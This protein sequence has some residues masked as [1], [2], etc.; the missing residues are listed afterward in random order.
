MTVAQGE[1]KRFA[2]QAEMALSL[3][4]LRSAETPSNLTCLRGLSLNGSNPSP[5]G[6]SAPYVSGDLGEDPLLETSLLLWL[7]R[8]PLAPYYS[9]TEVVM[10]SFRPTHQRA[11]TSNTHHVVEVLHMFPEDL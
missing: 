3:A 8:A 6:R 4:K 2:A 10:Q 11:H 5:C 7:S 1:T 9:H